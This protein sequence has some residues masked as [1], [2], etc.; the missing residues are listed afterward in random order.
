M[1]VDFFVL[2]SARG[3][4][5]LFFGSHTRA[6]CHLSFPAWQRESTNKTNNADG[7]GGGGGGWC[8]REERMWQKSETD[9][10]RDC[11]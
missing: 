1:R 10:I 8:V 9:F 3:I 11:C 4:L 7:G 6:R 5:P 2:F